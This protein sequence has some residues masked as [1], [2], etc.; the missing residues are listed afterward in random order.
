MFFFARLLRRAAGVGTVRVGTVRP[1]SFHWERRICLLTRR[2][3]LSWTIFLMVIAMPSVSGG[4]GTAQ[5]HR[6]PQARV[7]E[8]IDHTI[9]VRLLA[10]VPTA[11][12]HVEG[13]FELIDTQA[14]EVLSRHESAAE[15]Q[16]VVFQQ[17]RISLPDLALNLPMQSID[18]VPDRPG[19][20]SVGLRVGERVLHFPGR[21]RLIREQG[22]SGMVLNLAHIEDYLV[23]VVA[24]ELDRRFHPET[25]R[26]QSIAA[27]TYAWYHKRT[28]G[29][30]R[31]WDVTA[32]E[33]T[34]VYLGEDRARLVPE[35]AVAVRATRGI[36]CT[37]P[38]PA[39]WK[40]FC[41]YYSSACGGWTQSADA[42]RTDSAIAP[43]EGNVRC[44]H[45]K[46]A[47]SFFWGPL[48]VTKAELTARLRARYALFREKGPIRQVTVV[49]STP[50][51]RP[52]RFGLTDQA[53]RT[54]ELEAENVR[55]SIDPT[56]RI[57]RSTM[58]RFTD[59]PDRIIIEQGQ[60]FGH[61]VGWCQ[62]G[63]EGLAR[64]GV[65]A[66]EILE[67]YYPGSRLQRAY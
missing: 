62:F 55:L 63:A 5:A 20:S 25:F 46:D 51:G 65:L 53:G 4:T 16:R 32:D 54:T 38:S 33:Q 24:S 6:T 13:P 8:A 49:Q 48:E 43:L 59:A 41:T 30:R 10:G 1:R 23:G 58:F 35:A 29:M 7:A 56:G 57:F 17:D 22:G 40:I 21:L 42:I 47:P 61:G 64:E 26:A 44:L 27:R 28:L 36:V 34:Q 9:R 3:G 18:I 67:R 2:P 31:D 45:C 66:G 14:E 50:A 12:I 39:G 11:Q 37:W 60:G 15:R 19:E 52:V